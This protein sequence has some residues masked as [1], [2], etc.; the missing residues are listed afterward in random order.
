MMVFIR[1]WIFLILY[2]ARRQLRSR[3]VFIAGGLLALTAGLVALMA[4][5]RGMTPEFFGEWVVVRLFGLFIF[6]LLMLIFGAGAL[7][8]DRDE[9]TLVYLITRPLARWGIYLGKFLSVLPAAALFGIGGFWLLCQAGRLSDP[10]EL[11]GIFERFAAAFLFAAPAY[12]ALFHF[13]AAAFRHSMLIS[14]T[15]VFFVEVFIGNVPGIL[16]RVSI[17]FYTSSMVYEAGEAIGVQPPSR[18]IFQ[19][20]EGDL[21]RWVL[22]GIA[23]GFLLLGS[24]WFNGYEERERGV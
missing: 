7:A 17:H 3:K 12:L 22:L 13:F 10:E 23:L 2:S 5:R 9:G 19:P 4:L 16:K 24:W 15:Y 20:L 1:A 6:P 8:D 21:A 14:V 18:I 11:Q